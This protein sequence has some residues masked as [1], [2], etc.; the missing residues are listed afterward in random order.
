MAPLRAIFVVAAVAALGTQSLALDV[1]AQR[2]HAPP[3]FPAAAPRALPFPRLR[4]GRTLVRSADSE[5]AS[6]WQ[7][8][9]VI[10]RGERGDTNR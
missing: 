8:R 3:P 5:S 1:S 2:E 7:V 10:V 6:L 9:I 4:S